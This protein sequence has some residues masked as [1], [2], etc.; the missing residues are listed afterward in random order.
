MR[1]ELAE[2]AEGIA[3]E[4]QERGSEDEEEALEAFES[5]MD[6]R[7]KLREQKT[8]RGYPTLVAVI[9]GS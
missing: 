7:R 6:I 8:N 2:A 3:S 1:Q 9:N 5:Y 4:F